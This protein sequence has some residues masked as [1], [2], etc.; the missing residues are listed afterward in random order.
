MAKIITI[1]NHKGGVGKTTTA[2]SLGHGL[3]MR[4]KTVLLLDLDAQAQLAS[5]LNI[6]QSDA[7]YELLV[8]TRTTYDQLMVKTGRPKLWLIPGS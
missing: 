5:V 8:S 4:K 3:T 2:A 7:V 1:G 6:Q